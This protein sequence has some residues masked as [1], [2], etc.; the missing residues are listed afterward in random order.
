MTAFEERLTKV[1]KALSAQYEHALR[2]HGRSG[3]DLA[4]ADRTTKRAS[5][6]P[7]PRLQGARR[8]VARAL[9]V[10]RWRERDHGPSR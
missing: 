9:E 10:M 4:A 7:G 3:L 1:S 5:D 6:A 8:D 2:Q